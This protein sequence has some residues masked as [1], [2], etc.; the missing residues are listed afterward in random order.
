M[1][2]S[3]KY[4]ASVSKFQ[5]TIKLDLEKK[6]SNIYTMNNLLFN[7]LLMNLNNLK[8]GFIISTMIFGWLTAQAKSAVLETLSSEEKKSEKTEELASIV[9]NTAET[10]NDAFYTN[11]S[12]IAIDTSDVKER[13]MAPWTLNE[14]E[15]EELNSIRNRAIN[16]PIWTIYEKE[17]LKIYQ[18]DAMSA[19]ESMAVILWILDPD[20]TTSLWIWADS[21]ISKNKTLQFL[22]EWEIELIVS[23]FNLAKSEEDLA[24]SEEDLAKSEEDLAKWKEKLDKIKKENAE[25][26]KFLAIQE[27]LIAILKETQE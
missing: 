2:C 21:K 18:M 3:S 11:T 8:K 19:E 17:I 22:L 23:K 26:D 13:F 12:N 24:K 7:Y 9:D 15:K 5:K 10:M 4:P 20:R 27:N 6:K 14:K 1:I 25:L 16:S